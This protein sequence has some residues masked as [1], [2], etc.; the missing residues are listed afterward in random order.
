[1]GPPAASRL[2]SAAPGTGREDA[3]GKRTGR[4]LPFADFKVYDHAPH[5]LVLTDTDQ[6]NA[7]LLAFLSLTESQS[8]PVERISIDPTP[9]I[10]STSWH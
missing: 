5:A 8:T 10:Q 7:D 9:S 4:L 6:F 3:S 1:M 2:A